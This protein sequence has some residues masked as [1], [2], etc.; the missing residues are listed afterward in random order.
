M[1][2]VL[3][4]NAIKN[5]INKQ[6]DSYVYHLNPQEVKSQYPDKDFFFEIN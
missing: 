2:K 1:H 3:K 5:N 4:L 6:V